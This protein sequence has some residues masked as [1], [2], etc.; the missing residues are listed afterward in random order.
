MSRI[1]LIDRNNRDL[2]AIVEA[3]EALQERDGEGGEGT[4]TLTVEKARLGDTQRRVDVS[5]LVLGWGLDLADTSAAT[6]ELRSESLTISPVAG[7][8]TPDFRRVWY[9]VLQVQGT[10]VHIAAPLH[11]RRLRTY[12]ARIDIL[13]ANATVTWD[14]SVYLWPGGTAPSLSPHADA[15]H[16]LSLWVDSDG[17]VAA[18]LPPEFRH[19]PRVAAT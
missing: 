17:M 2:R 5:R 14:Q 18:V 11:S 8:V 7:V 3:L 6:A 12:V 16:Y 1:N 10:N 9:N 15:K 4:G 19:T 13:T